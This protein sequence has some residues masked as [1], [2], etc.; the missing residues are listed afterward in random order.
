MNVTATPQTGGGF[1]D[2]QGKITWNPV[3]S[4]L[5]I[6]INFTVSQSGDGSGPCGEISVQ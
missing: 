1:A 6:E 2:S 4:K 5:D 3:T